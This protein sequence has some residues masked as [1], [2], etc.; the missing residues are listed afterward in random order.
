MMEQ[1]E[2][3]RIVRLSEIG[4]TARSGELSADEEERKKL[5]RR[6]DLPKISRLEA[7][8]SL[9]AGEDRIGFTGQLESDLQQRCVVTGESFQVR[10]RE[11]FDI[12]FVPELDIASAEEEIEL[13]EEDCDIIEYE[14]GQLDLGE[15][16]AQTLYL[17]LDPFPRGPNADAVA[18][19][20]LKSE[21]EAGPFGALAALKDKL[22]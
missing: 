12:A 1:P 19:E 16:I 5:A 3:S 17:A 7:S 10:L 22:P 14:N 18:Q 20:V 4:S 6:F 2:F 15:A 11:D 13:T 8:Y 21:E 9:L